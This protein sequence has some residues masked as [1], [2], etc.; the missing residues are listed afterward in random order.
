MVK[1]GV[2]ELKNG[3]SRYLDL[4]KNGEQITVTQRGKEIAVISP[5]SD[6][7]VRDR[8]MRMVREGKASWSGRK[9]DLSKPPLR[10][11]GKP[12]SEIVIEDRG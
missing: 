6:D 8:I 4:V 3:L 2:R 1:V 11:G 12:L 10:I 7:A 5:V 9:P